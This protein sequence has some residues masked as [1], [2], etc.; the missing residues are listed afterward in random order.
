MSTRHYMHT[1]GLLYSCAVIDRNVRFQFDGEHVSTPPSVDLLW[2]ET[3]RSDMW[4]G[5]IKNCMLTPM[6]ASLIT[7]VP[8][9][10]AIMLIATKCSVSLYLSVVS[11]CLY[12][13]VHLY[14]VYMHSQ[15]SMLPCSS[16][17]FARSGDLKCHFLIFIILFWEG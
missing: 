16:Y 13:F 3:V 8:A 6:H 12:I 14:Y 2:S 1:N 9:R 7:S 4:F 5:Y 10:C 15:F 17:V 11:F